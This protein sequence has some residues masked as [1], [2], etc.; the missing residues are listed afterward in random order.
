[1]RHLDSIA[2]F[3]E[4]ARTGSFTAAARTLQMPLS[5]VSRKVAE[6][7]AELQIRLLD[8]SR[9]PLRMTEAGQAYFD[10]SSKG[11]DALTYANQAMRGKQETLSGTLRITVP[12]NLT[13]LLF[14]KP[15]DRFVRRHPDA[16]VR[17]LV[18]ERMLDFVDD[19]IDLSFRVARP[20]AP[21]LVIRKLLVHRHRLCAAPSYLAVHALPR[22]PAELSE[23]VRLGFGF[24]SQDSIAW[25]LTRGET[26]Y[27]EPFEPTVAIND[28]LALKAAI[29]QG[30]GIGELPGLLCKDDLASGRLVEILPD[31]RLPE[32]SLYAVYAGKVGL[33]KLARGFLDEV[34]AHTASF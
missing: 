14:V 29:E 9:K 8:R 23:H 21:N 20:A 18:S 19:A 12:P 27:S 32:I 10:L 1:M 31:W 3:V 16:R 30:T 11:I 28:Y 4:V 34:A 25:Q 33:S 13:E 15:I 17:V 24:Q 5:S 7:E 6:L 2:V 26:S 22:E